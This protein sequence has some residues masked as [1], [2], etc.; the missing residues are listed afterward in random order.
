MTDSP[1]SELRNDEE[2]I[3]LEDAIRELKT[4]DKLTEDV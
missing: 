1:I 2:K 3:P 4:K